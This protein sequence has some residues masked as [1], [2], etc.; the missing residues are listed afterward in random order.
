MSESTTR[1]SVGLLILLVTLCPLV[2]G[3]QLGADSQ[4]YP[5]QV[6][7]AGSS[8]GLW[9][10]A[11]QDNDEN[12]LHVTFRNTKGE[13]HKHAPLAGGT[14]SG[15]AALD[16]WAY[17]SFSDGTILQI[18]LL[19][20][21]VLPVLPDNA[22]AHALLADSQTKQLYALARQTH[23]QDYATGLGRD[24]I[25]NPGPNLQSGSLISSQ[26]RP[27]ERCNWQIFSLTAGEWQY[28]T[29]LPQEVSLQTKPLVMARNQRLEVLWQG[30]D[31][32]FVYSQFEQQWSDHQ[33]LPIEA[34]RSLWFCA[35]P[36][37]L[38]IISARDTGPSNNWQLQLY[39]LA[40][41]L[42]QQSGQLSAP[43]GVFQA[44]VGAI[45]FTSQADHIVGFWQDGN[46]FLT[47]KWDAGGSQVGQIEDVSA[48][49]LGPEQIKNE[50]DII[51]TAM[52]I[53]L[54]VLVLLMRGN[55]L[56]MPVTLPEGWQLCQYWRRALGFVI[57]MIPPMVIASIM[58]HDFMFDPE[59][60]NQAMLAMQ[61]GQM[62]QQMYWLAIFINVGYGVYC[63]L[64][65]WLTGTSL[66][67]WALGLQVRNIRNISD[68]PTVLQLLIRNGLK[69]VELYL[70]LP[71]FVVFFTRNRQR[72]GDLVAGT[73][74]IQK[75]RQGDNTG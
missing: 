61:R 75:I 26:A 24:N 15:F 14:I 31:G 52:L 17:A 5:Q 42:W 66:G 54:L 50:P 2:A 30:T 22:L 29:C 33:F 32:R 40:G 13:F 18:G 46:K 25:R 27:Q 35:L 47:G 6:W 64:A 65:E 55:W 62:D 73:L 44:G 57:D 74:V 39:R 28:L 63:F 71:I 67:K 41:N 37:Q 21:K 19:T 4:F 69:A 36:D 8:T 10:A 45:D 43:A 12:I 7:C 23:E 68:R 9:L 60:Q 58:W 72:L 70:F 20:E 34:A 1:N 53:A 56:A 49:V 51:S 59:R 3:E 16:N 11:R 48:Q 38:M